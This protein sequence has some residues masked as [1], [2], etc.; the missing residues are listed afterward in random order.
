MDEI[1]CPACG[2]TDDLTG[3]RVDALIS[4]TCGVCGATWTRDPS[5]SCP[6]CGRRDV[7]EAVQAVVD[8]SRGTQLSIQSF[9][10]VHLCPDCD[11]ARLRRW[12]DSNTPLP[13]DELPTS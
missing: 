12:L 7:R 8:K 2:E 1:S 5:P 6:H 13:P 3:S 9:R 10:V 11:A 4:I